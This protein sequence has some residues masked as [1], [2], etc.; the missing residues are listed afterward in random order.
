M[1]SFD[2]SICIFTDIKLQL[3]QL[4]CYQAFPNFSYFLRVLLDNLYQ[5]HASYPDFVFGYNLLKSL[6]AKF[7]QQAL[8]FEH[9]V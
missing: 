6:H 9:Q 8:L 2:H 7:L 1:S 4:C 5:L 3:T